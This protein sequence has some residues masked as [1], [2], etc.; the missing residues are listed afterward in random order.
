MTDSQLIDDLGGPAQLAERLGYSAKA[1]GIQRVHN[2]RRRGIPAAVKLQHPDLFLLDLHATS[3]AE[4]QQ[5][6]ETHDAA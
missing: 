5:A 2:W 1:G 3:A 6:Q 4:R